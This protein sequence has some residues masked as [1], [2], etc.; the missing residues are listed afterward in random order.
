MF[1]KFKEM[2]ANL[3]ELLKGT[4]EKV[5]KDYVNMIEEVVKSQVLPPKLEHPGKFTISCNISEVNISYALCDMGSSINF[6]P[7]KMVKE[8]NMGEIT[9]MLYTKGTLGGF[10]I[11][12]RPFLE[13]GK[14]KIDVETGE[15]ILKFVDRFVRR[16]YGIVEDVLVKIDKFVFPVDFVILEVP[17]D[18]EIP[19]ILGRPFLETGQCMIDIEEGTMTLKVYDEE[20]KIDVRNTMQ[21]KD[22]IGIS[23]TVEI[24]N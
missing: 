9:P 2:L 24:I 20:L 16:P 3:Q 7:L 23:H 22:D 10:A 8:F 15:L 6:M 12:G 21:Y 13:I 5:G 11:L 18:E 17:E 4:K 14:A 19:L 1:A